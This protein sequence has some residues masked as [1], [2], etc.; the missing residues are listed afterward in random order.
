MSFLY[1]W[2]AGGR[3]GGQ[4]PSNFCPEHISYTH[5]GILMKLYRYIYHYEKPCRAHKQKK[6]MKE[7]QTKM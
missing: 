5:G 7:I 4:S 6:L 2:R 1:A 3:T